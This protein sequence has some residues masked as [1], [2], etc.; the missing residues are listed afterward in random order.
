MA[1]TLDHIADEIDAMGPSATVGADADSL[2]V[3][4]GHGSVASG[5][6]RPMSTAA[7]EQSIAA[8]FEHVRRLGDQLSAGEASDRIRLWRGVLELVAA[9]LAG[10]VHDGVLWRGLDVLDG[11]DLR[12]WLGRH[13]ADQQTLMRSPVLRGLYD[14]TFAYRGGD[15]RRPSLAAGRGLQSLLLMINYEGSFMWRMRAGMGDVVFSPL[16]LALRRRGVSFRFFSQVTRLRLM[17]GRPVVEA[18]DLT[19]RATI[20]GGR[21]GMTRSSASASGGVGRRRPY[22]EQLIDREPHA[23]TL[24]RGADFD[25]VVLAIPVGALSEICRELAEADSR[26][27]HDARAARRQCGQRACSCG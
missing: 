23:E 16:Y 22:R 4:R 20:A 13:G 2:S 8:L 9:S 24:V 5:L 25:D 27:K 14:L 12:D 10:I 6:R 7:V 3:T 17:P 11:E 18:I 15:K 1:A 19:R 26:F 21:T